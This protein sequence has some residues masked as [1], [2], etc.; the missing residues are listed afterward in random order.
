MEAG[1]DLDALID[2]RIFGRKH[3]TQEEMKAE[4]ERV[5]E[6]QPQCG[7]FLAGFSNVGPIGCPRFEMNMPRY[8]T[9]IAAAWQVV[10][11]VLLTTNFTEFRMK[12]GIFK[13]HYGAGFGAYGI[14]GN[15]WPPTAPGEL[16]K[17]EALGSE[18]AH[19]ICLAAL[20]ALGAQVND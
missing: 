15:P 16:Y 19:A 14:S 17:V 4:A 5:W 13:G 10:E 9:D 1:R 20:K 6:K 3:L 11:Q 18:P 7:R 12:V 2:Q 8:S